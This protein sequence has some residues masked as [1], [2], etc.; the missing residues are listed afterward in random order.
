M[1][2]VLSWVKQNVFIVV[3]GVVII[4]AAVGGPL[5]AS[6]LNEGVN[7]RLEDRAKKFSELSSLEKTQVTNPSTQE[8]ITTVVNEQLLNRYRDVVESQAADAQRVREM[9]VNH[10]RKNFSLILPPGWDPNAVYLFPEPID[11]QVLDY[12]PGE[13]WELVSG[14]YQSIVDSVGAG[15]PPSTEDI[16]EDIRRAD[17]Q[18]R[19]TQLFKNVT[20]ELSADEQQKLRDHLQQVRLGRYNEIAK[21]VSFYASPNQLAI[22]SFDPAAA[23]GLADMFVWQWDTWIVQ[24]ILEAIATANADSR[25]VLDAPVKRLLYL[26]VHDNPTAASQGGSS[27]SSGSSGGSAPGF[28]GAGEGGFGAGRG[29]KPPDA[30]TPVLPANPKMPVPTDFNW[31]FTGRKTN[32]LYDVRRASLGLVVEAQRLP[33]VLDALAKQNFFTVLNM[34]LAPAEP[35]DHVREGFMYGSKPV[36]RV[37]MEIETVWLREWTTEFMPPDLKTIL[38]IPLPVD[39]NAQAPIDP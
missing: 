38:S 12:R 10:N 17:G 19:L 20:D 5:V 25:N 26:Q 15:M 24:D 9:A 8:V 16:S 29:P 13:F 28:G 7:K 34:E 18:F 35:F 33:D 1:N 36:L 14:K 3:F 37:A 31:S 27:G 39:P 23:I 22:P 2:N 6:M 4:A 30:A 32:P 21:S 11:R